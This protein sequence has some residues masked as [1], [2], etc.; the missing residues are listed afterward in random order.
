MH[1]PPPVYEL[2]PLL[3]ISILA[4]LIAMAYSLYCEITHAEEDDDQTD[5]EVD[6]GG[7]QQALEPYSGRKW[8][9]DDLP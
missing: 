4:G 3:L 1:N 7:S 9:R 5:F 2:I 8:Q 6:L